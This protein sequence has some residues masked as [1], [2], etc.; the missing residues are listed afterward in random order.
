MSQRHVAA[1][2]A[3]ERAHYLRAIAGDEMGK[4]A[5]R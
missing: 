1:P 4:R 2:A 3:F 5:A